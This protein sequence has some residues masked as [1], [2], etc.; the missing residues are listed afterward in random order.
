[1]SLV[2]MMSVKTVVMIVRA[3]TG[4]EGGLMNRK[5]EAMMWE[6]QKGVQS[7]TG[8]ALCYVLSH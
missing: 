2:D 3:V 4:T 8:V 5:K 7:V 1:M 6:G